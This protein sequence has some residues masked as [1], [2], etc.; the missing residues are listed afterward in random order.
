MPKRSHLGLREKRD[1][2]RKRERERDRERERGNKSK[3]F[4][5]DF[6]GF[7]RSELG[8]PRVK[9]ALRNES[10]TWVLEYKVQGLGFQGN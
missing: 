2:K 10:Y 3:P 1:R 6:I 9:V 4:S 5:S 8:K 7:C